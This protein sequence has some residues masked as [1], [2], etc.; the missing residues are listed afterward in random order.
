MSFRLDY[1]EPIPKLVE[2]L[3]GEH[4]ELHV[5]LERIVS[6]IKIGNLPVAISLLNL[7]KAEILR[8]AVEEEA[9]LVRS[10]MEESR[11]ESNQSIEIMQ[12]HRRIE[13]FLQIK[14][15]HLGELP[16]NKATREIE[17]F[18]NELERHHLE[19]E[20]IVFPLAIKS[21]LLHSQKMKSN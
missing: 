10:I 15:P 1:N 5:K 18:V 12:Q 20:R 9:R 16:P 13:E 2:R 14:L 3:K 8:H 6:E 17:E 19:E 7:D 4:N 11:D 21:D